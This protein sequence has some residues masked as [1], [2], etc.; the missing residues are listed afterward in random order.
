MP[1]FVR[2]ITSRL[3]S[4]IN[5]VFI[6]PNVRGN[7]Q[8]MEKFLSEP[9]AAADGTGYLCGDHLTAADI[10]LSFP[11][12]AARARCKDLGPWEGGSAEAEFP[13][14]FAYLARLEKEPGYQK[15][16]QTIEEVDGKFSALP[17]P[18]AH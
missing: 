11:L 8:L 14:T 17:K 18:R 4:Q 2:P 13:I 6:L 7:L 3:A 16:I 15:S 12:L 9:P 10:L 1:W 5:S